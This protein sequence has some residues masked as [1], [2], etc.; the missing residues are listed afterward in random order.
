MHY[1]FLA[2]ILVSC[3]AFSGT[4]T[5]VFA[6]TN[7]EVSGSLKLSFNIRKSNSN[8]ARSWINTNL[9][10][11]RKNLENRILR[12]K[13]K[14]QKENQEKLLSQRK[15]TNVSD[16][17][18]NNSDGSSLLISKLP[19]VTVKIGNASTVADANG[20]FSVIGLKVGQYPLI[21]LIK[22]MKYTNQQ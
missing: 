21:F 20:N 10:S 15:K 22:I 7:G 11:T 19:F 12:E 1:C 6:S 9:V 17:F 2:S 8:A 5:Q 16:F 18:K 4:T 13:N 14:T 3:F